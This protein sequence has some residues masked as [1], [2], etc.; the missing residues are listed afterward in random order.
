MQDTSRCSL[1]Y[2]L[3]SNQLKKPHLLSKTSRCYWSRDHFILL[4]IYSNFSIIKQVWLINLCHKIPLSTESKTRPLFGAKVTSIKMKH[5]FTHTKCEVAGEMK[6]KVNIWQPHVTCNHTV[7]SRGHTHDKTRDRLML[8]AGYRHR[9][10][11]SSFRGSVLPL[12]VHYSSLTILFA[13]S[14]THL[15]GWQTVLHVH[16]QFEVPLAS[17]LVQ[18]GVSAIKEQL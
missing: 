16:V 1:R 5:T 11:P 10:S 18:L 17:F 2:L 12:T 6:V 9:L 15:P 13:H 4:F 14:E 7:L 3:L 8:T